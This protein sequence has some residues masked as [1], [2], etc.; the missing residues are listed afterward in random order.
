[1]S[2]NDRRGGPSTTL[3]KLKPGR[4]INLNKLL[5]VE[6]GRAGREVGGSHLQKYY[7]KHSPAEDG[8]AWGGKTIPEGKFQVGEVLKQ[9]Y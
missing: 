8:F 2:S 6:K 7:V 1:V 9:W 5:G 4:L 3:P